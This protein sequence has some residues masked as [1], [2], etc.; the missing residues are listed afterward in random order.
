MRKILI[1]LLLVVLFALV[2]VGGVLAQPSQAISLDNLVTAINIGNI[3]PQNILTQAILN[4]VKSGVP[5]T[6]IVLLLLLPAVATF[7]AAARNIVGVRGFGIFLPAA[8]SVVF[9]AIG[10]ILGISLFLLIVTISTLVRVT[11]RKL[12]LRLQYLPRMSL[13]LWFVVVGVLS[14]FFALPV[15]NF[16]DITQVSV[17]AVLILALLSEDFTRVQMGKSARTAIELTGETLILALISYLFLTFKSIQEIAL[18]NPEAFLLSVFAIDLLL[19]RYSG[20]R[21]LEIW[22]FRKLIF[23]K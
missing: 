10:P 7:I 23:L 12:K 5:A 16:P 22:R 2:S 1:F 19:S 18:L 6:T 13:I 21:L 8:L 3:G 17:F 14:V 4:A 11:L 9:V 15:L 20:L